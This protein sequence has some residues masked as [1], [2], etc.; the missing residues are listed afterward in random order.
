MVIGTIPA[1]IA[2]KE[3]LIVWAVAE[4]R[5]ELAAANASVQYPKQI[6][7]AQGYF[8]S[9]VIA[10]QEISTVDGGSRHIL[11]VLMPVSPAYY[12]ADAPV[13]QFCGQILP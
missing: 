13:Y 5:R 2:T 4:I 8:P 10:I 3:Q 12:G 1:D 9:D 11:R 7:E 6:T